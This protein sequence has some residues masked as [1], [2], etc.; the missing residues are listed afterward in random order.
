MATTAEIAAMRVALDASRCA[1]GTT[2]P[3]P[4]VGAAVVD[5]T[6]VVIATG[7]T[8]PPGGA[9]AEV[10]ALAIAGAAARGG[11]AVTTLEPCAHIGRTGACTDAILGSGI[12]RVVYAVDDPNPVAAGGADLLRAAGVDVEGGCLAEEAMHGP[13]EAWLTALRTGRP[14]VTWKYAASLDGRVA[15]ADGS[16]RWVT[17]A[18]ARAD[19]HCLRAES[20]AVIVGVGTVLADDPRLTVRDDAGATAAR[21]PLRVVLDSHGRTPEDALVRNDDAET[22]VLSRHAIGGG[23]DGLDLDAAL[24]VLHDRGVRSVLLEGGPTLAG[25]FFRAGLVDRVVAYL[26]PAL[27]GGGGLPAL[28]GD[29]APSIDKAWRLRLDSVDRVGDDLRVVARPVAR[30]R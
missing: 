3:N 19:A 12:R 9:H 7:C 11:T 28:G 4:P 20:D 27:I 17:G 6:G 1:L 16:S 23:D 13:L 10:A 22:L 21:Q 15:A 14:F 8:A 18:A 25:A 2:S 5:E 24:R 29:G 30:D 26:A